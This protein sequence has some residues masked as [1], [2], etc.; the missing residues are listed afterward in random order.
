MKQ[1]FLDAP[2]ATQNPLIHHRVCPVAWNLIYY[3]MEKGRKVSLAS[4]LLNEEGWT[5]ER[6]MKVTTMI[7]LN[8]LGPAL[9]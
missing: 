9:R 4:R 1:A 8:A 5:S 6:M 7:I 2:K 3:E